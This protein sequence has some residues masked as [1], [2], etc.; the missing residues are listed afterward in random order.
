MM[1]NKLD[2][3][4]EMNGVYDPDETIQDELL[5]SMDSLQ[6]VQLVVSIE[7]EFDVGIPDEYLLFKYFSTKEK[8]AKI[9][10][11]AII[12]GYRNVDDIVNSNMCI[13]CL[14]CVQL[15]PHGELKV[16]QDKYPYP[17][18]IKAEGCNSCS[19]CLLECPVKT[20]KNIFDCS[21]GGSDENQT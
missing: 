18:P 12:D 20:N 21:L 8:I 17:I 1:L 14:A 13:G 9:I 5:S 4:L 11:Q 3:V 19:N 2:D 15:C 6:F 7:N 10:E 16:V